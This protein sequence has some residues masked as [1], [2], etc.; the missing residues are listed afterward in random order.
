MEWDRSWRICGDE[1]SIDK[2]SCEFLVDQE[3][4]EPF[5]FL[6]GR[7]T[8]VGEN[9]EYLL[10]WVTLVGYREIPEEED[11]KSRACAGE[12][13]RSYISLLYLGL[14]VDVWHACIWHFCLVRFSSMS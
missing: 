1:C 11:E 13:T 4:G 9:G 5:A 10:M 7:D 2:S 8:A 12:R 3:G 6:I 14:T